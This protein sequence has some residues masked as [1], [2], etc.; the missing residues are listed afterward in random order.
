MAP[1]ERPLVVAA[2]RL[3]LTR[4]ED[5][6]WTTSPG[7]LV[8]ALLPT[9]QET[10]GSWVGWTGE[11]DGPSRSSTP[12]VPTSI[13]SR[14]AATRSTATT[15]VS[16]TGRSGRCITTR[17]ALIELLLDEWTAAVDVNQR[18]GIQIANIA[19][20]HA[21]VWVHDYHLQLVLN[22]LRELRND[23]RIEGPT[24]FPSRRSSCSNA[25]RGGARSSGP[26][27]APTC[28]ASSAARAPT[29]AV[30]AAQ[31]LLHATELDT[32]LIHFEG[33]NVNVGAYLISIDVADFELQASGRATRQHGADPQ[34]ARRPRRSSCSASTARLPKGI[35]NRLLLLGELFDQGRL[36]PERQP[37]WSRWRRR[38]AEGVEQYQDEWRDRTDRRRDQRRHS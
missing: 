13:R 7:G 4:A 27:S 2:N 11:R 34:P 14:S 5:G 25:C 3:P 23:V 16:P 10:K 15:R 8:R 29:T 17:S 37:S 21:A 9:V 22:L 28:S 1:T 33:C 30:S 18:F 26:P 31:H 38:R 12:T 20:P 24:T 19:P 6:S 32:G 35:G 36:D